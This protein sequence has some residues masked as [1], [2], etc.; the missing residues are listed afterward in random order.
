MASLLSF[1]LAAKGQSD[2]HS[3]VFDPDL[4]T[5]QLYANQTG[6][7]Y[8]TLN[9]P[10]AS[11]NSGQS[12]ILEFDDLRASYR[13]F[14]IKIVSYNLDGT[15]SKLRDLEFL[16][17]YNDFI[18]N[19]FEV[20]Q[21][22]KVNYYHYG[23]RLPQIKIA[24]NYMLE[25][26]END[27][28]GN[29]LAQMTFQV[30]DPQVTVLAQA[31]RPQD[32]EF[33]QSHQQVDFE[34]NYGNYPL[35]D[36]RNELTVLIR[37]NFRDTDVKTGFKPTAINAGRSTLGY[38]FFANENLFLAGNEF[39][40]LDIRSTYTRGE[41]VED[42]QQGYE[43]QVFMKDQFKR[44][45]QTYLAKNDLDGRYVVE[46]LEDQHPSISA[47]YV[48]VNFGFKSHVLMPNQLLCIVGTFNDYQCDIQNALS[49]SSEYEGYTGAM[50]LKQ[51]VYDYQFVVKEANG[52][53]N[54]GILEGD[55][56]NTGNSYEVFVY[57]KQPSAKT[58]RL[59]GYSLIRSN[60]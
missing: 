37:K 46:T 33:W 51:G 35:R 14:H 39:R 40:R 43:D 22:T 55:F 53:L 36:P 23:F 20:S 2:Y 10:V 57:H 4:H 28:Y 3:E 44:A 45:D 56:T 26:Y 11:L 27:L 21:G 9:S 42:V 47:D 59:I 50:L 6:E 49:F 13:Q 48:R 58:E 34:I 15:V 54:F 16:N 29:K 18:I 25:L 38:K 24:G 52:Q 60:Q 5:V 8:A 17:E 19:N 12:L 7:N 1:C 30:L 41:N 31:Q 32:P